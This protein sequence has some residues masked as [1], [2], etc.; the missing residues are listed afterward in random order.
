MSSCWKCSSGSPAIEIE[1]IPRGRVWKVRR[2]EKKA[3]TSENCP[4]VC[5]NE[6]AKTFKPGVSL[7]FPNL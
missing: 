7:L 6:M 3:I 1:E 5:F 4:R 2:V